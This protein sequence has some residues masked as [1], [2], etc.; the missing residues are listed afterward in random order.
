LNGYTK[1][2]HPP[3]TFRQ[4]SQTRNPSRAGPSQPSRDPCQVDVSSKSRQERIQCFPRNPSEGYGET[5]RSSLTHVQCWTVS[6]DSNRLFGSFQCSKRRRT[7][8]MHG[9]WQGSPRRHNRRTPVVPIRSLGHRVGVPTLGPSIQRNEKSGPPR[10]AILK[11]SSHPFPRE[12]LII[13]GRAAKASRSCLTDR[14]RKAQGARIRR[15]TG[16][17]R[18]PGR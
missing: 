16:H 17:W 5:R 7:R 10:S 9:G 15:R 1:G 18:Q 12:V 13:D 11:R 2:V 3:S 6:S 4:L 14:H 8:A